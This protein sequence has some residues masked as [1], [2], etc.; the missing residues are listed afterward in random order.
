MEIGFWKHQLKVGISLFMEI[1]CFVFA[2]T[3]IVLVVKESFYWIV[4]VFAIVMLLLNT[5]AVFFE[6]KILYKVFFSNKGIRVKRLKKELLFI[7]W[8]DITEV[9]A[10]PYARG[11]SYLSFMIVNNQLDVDLTKK[12]YDTIMIL[13]PY[14]GIKTMINNLP[15]FKWYHREK[16]K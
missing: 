5:Y 11:D 12:M 16:K 15:Q 10:T 6:A 4:L 14:T 2:V 8:E 9:K 3:S 7:N 1:L 13:C